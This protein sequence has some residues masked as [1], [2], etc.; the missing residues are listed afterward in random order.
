[1][2][3]EHAILAAIAADPEDDTARLA[4]ADFVEENGEPDRAAFIRN[5]VELARLKSGDP[6]LYHLVKQNN[7]FHYEYVPFWRAGLPHLPGIEWGHFKRGLIEEVQ[8]ESEV[9]IVGNAKEIFAQPAIHIIRLARFGGT[10]VFAQMPE[11]ARIRSLRF[12]GAGATSRDLL[13]LLASP[14]LEN[15]AV[16]DLHDNRADDACAEVLAET[17]FPSLRELWLGSNRVGNSGGRAL[18]ECTGLQ[19]LCFLDL[20]NNLITDNS[21]FTAL[22]RRLGSNL[23]F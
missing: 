6:A 7:R 1:M 3:D 18:A 17:P 21:V 22:V 16:L 20:R 5:Q 9:A 10:R 23:K 15:L 14:Y 4:Y 12:I 13:R 11:L 2:T 8:A 19:Q